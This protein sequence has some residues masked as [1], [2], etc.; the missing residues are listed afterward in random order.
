MAATTVTPMATA[1]PAF[2]MDPTS[3]EHD[4][5]FPRR[6]AGSENPHMMRADDDIRASLRELNGDL[7][8]AYDDAASSK[9]LGPALFPLLQDA[10]ADSNESLDQMQQDDPLATQVWKFFA[11]TKQQLP[12]QH[13][14]ENLTWRMMAL[15]MR[16][17]KQQMQKK[18]VISGLC[19]RLLGLR[20]SLIFAHV[21][22]TTLSIPEC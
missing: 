8:G 3:T 11:R 2:T 18:Y 20:F 16:R 12:N 21:L 6:P 13:R 17:H 15:G 4:W 9:L 10:N 19:M 14:M 5:R 7:D 1:S 22:T